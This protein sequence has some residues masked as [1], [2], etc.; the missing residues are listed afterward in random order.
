[1]DLF[2]GRVY[3]EF[4]GGGRQSVNAIVGLN[5]DVRNEVT[6]NLVVDR[7][8]EFAAAGEWDLDANGRSAW[9]ANLAVGNYRESPGAVQAWRESGE[10]GARHGF[11]LGDKAE[12][13]VDLSFRKSFYDSGG[14]LGV[15][16]AKLGA[17]G[18]I[19]RRFR[20]AARYVR[21]FGSGKSPFQFDNIDIEN[22]LFTRFAWSFGQWGVGTTTRYDITDREFRRAQF[23]LSKA[24]HCIQ[25][26]VSY[27]T[28][29][30]EVGLRVSLPGL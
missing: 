27:D 29:L 16:T 6:R 30:H 21:R 22:E 9:Y 4:A 10:V 18:T 23:G 28:V 8:P 2:R 19:G 24:V 5:E 3:A 26:G 12:G 11:P 15:T 1:M 25:Y 7:L 17:K 14:S 20:G 13:T